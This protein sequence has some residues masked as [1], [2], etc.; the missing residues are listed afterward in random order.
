LAYNLTVWTHNLLAAQSPKLRMYGLLRMVR[1][2]FHIDGRVQID[3]QGHI[4]NIALN[5][6][7]ELAQLS[8]TGRVPSWVHDEACLGLGQN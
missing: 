8:V 3:A 4:R 2:V 7:D 6:A 1:D 5:Q